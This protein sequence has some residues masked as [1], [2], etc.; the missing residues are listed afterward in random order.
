M[1]TLAHALTCQGFAVSLV[2]FPGPLADRWRTAI[3]SDP[4]IAPPV[5]DPDNFKFKAAYL[6]WRTYRNCAE[7]HDAVVLFTYYLVVPAVFYRI[8]LR[9]K[10][11]RLI[12][13]MHDNLP[14][15]RGRLLLQIF[16]LATH[17]I[18]AV[19]NFTAKQFGA[20]KGRVIVITRPVDPVDAAP[21]VGGALTGGMPRVGI[22]GRLVRDK[23]HMLLIKAAALLKGDV[24]VIVRGAGDG[25]QY[26]VTDEVVS[27]G[28]S[29]L[30]SQF[31]F[32]GPVPR[33]RTMD[34]LDALVVGN[35]REPLG[36]TVIEAQLSGVVAIVPDTGGSSE[37]VRHGVT[38]LKYTAGSAES[39]AGALRY[40]AS[41]PVLT[42]QIIRA[43][44]SWAE[45]TSTPEKYAESY[46]EAIQPSP[47]EHRT[48]Q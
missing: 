14:G 48:L 23:G 21:S 45:L 32:E 3:G 26:D 4:V 19:S 1:L 17:R 28:C 40:M 39:L 18:I 22:V 25:S 2:C 24:E 42:E 9:R 30:G 20:L 16:S 5:L 11:V 46:L 27:L 15:A 34:G 44:R 43:A 6:L 7:T 31:R 38:G 29:V 41:N 35:E 10:R 37:L 8:V 47:A 33:S 12:L 13:D 36:R